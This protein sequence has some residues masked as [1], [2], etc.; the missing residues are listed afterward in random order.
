MSATY[1]SFT[2]TDCNVTVQS[3]R[4]VCSTVPGVGANHK[5]TVTVAG[6]TSAASV[7]TTSY[8]PPVVSGFSGL[9]EFSTVGG[10]GVTITGSNFGAQ[11][12]NV[13]A[14]YGPSSN[15]LAYTAF[16][17]SVLVAHTT[18]L[19]HTVEG[20]GTSMQWQVCATV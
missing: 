18:V 9:T 20:R 17:C 8:A 4:I 11:G 5:W 3:T 19:C 2:A 13:T 12:T 6:Q 7:N 14:T 1:G 16:N 15:V 10:T